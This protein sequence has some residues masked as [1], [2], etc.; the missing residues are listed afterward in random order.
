[1]CKAILKHRY[2]SIFQT[3]FSQDPDFIDQQHHHHSCSHVAQ[4]GVRE[5]SSWDG[6]RNNQGLTTFTHIRAQ[7][8][9][10]IDRL[11]EVRAELPEQWVASRLLAQQDQKQAEE[12]FCH[13]GQCA[14]A[15]RGRPWHKAGGDFPP[16]PSL[17]GSPP[18]EP[19]H[20]VSEGPQT[21]VNF[22][23]G[24]SPRRHRC[25]P[26]PVR[27][28]HWRQSQFLHGSRRKMRQWKG[29]IRKTPGRTA[30]N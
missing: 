7:V 30:I 24:F 25:N 14:G 1:M 23:Q 19:G 2:L 18:D 5:K 16:A 27:G 21:R 28:R 10:W 8:Y 15:T 4:V 29:Y 26:G 17:M 13:P 20:Q 22:D 12:R 3:T 6:A 11:A 9:E